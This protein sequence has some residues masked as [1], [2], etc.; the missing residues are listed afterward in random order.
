MTVRRIDNVGI[1]VRDV[2]LVAGFFEETL[3]LAVERYPD[4]DPPA[5]TITLEGSYLYLF[6]TASTVERAGREPSLTRNP[7]G[8]DHVSFGVDDVD[9]AFETLRERGVA[10]ADEPSTLEEWGIRLVPFTDPEGNVYFL[11]QTLG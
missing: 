7:P 2:E 1:A 8:I 10:F 6:Q 5:A 4:A 3:G 9:A 11:V